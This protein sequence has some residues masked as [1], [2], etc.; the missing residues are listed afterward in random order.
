MPEWLL[1]VVSVHLHKVA[2][3]GGCFGFQS[4]N[5]LKEAAELF[6]IYNMVHITL[7]KAL[8]EVIYGCV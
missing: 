3:T 6:S 5:D 1:A 8:L 4:V 2:G 7:L